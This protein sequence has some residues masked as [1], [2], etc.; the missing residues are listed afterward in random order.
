MPESVRIWL[1]V[2]HH[3]AFRIGGWAFVR[4]NA[5]EVSGTAG[6]ARAIDLERVSLAALAAALTR[7]IAALPPMAK[8]AAKAREDYGDAYCGGQIEASLR[9]VFESHSS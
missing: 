3:A 1:E 8:L 2:A 6:G 4:A 9:K 7:R 5:G